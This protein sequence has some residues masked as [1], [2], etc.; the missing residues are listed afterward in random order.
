MFRFTIKPSA[1]SHS[2]YLA[3]ITHSVQCAYMEVVQT[4][5][6]LWLH[7]MT[8]ALQHTRNI[9]CSVS[10]FSNSVNAQMTMTRGG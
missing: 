8:C 9:Y 5:S 3:K 6:V 4:L 7:S 2:Q 10:T 1:G